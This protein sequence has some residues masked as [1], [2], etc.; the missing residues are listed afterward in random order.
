M[1]RPRV[2]TNEKY[3]ICTFY[4][5]FVYVSSVARWSRKSKF[6][7]NTL[8]VRGIH[9][10]GFVL[11]LCV[12]HSITSSWHRVRSIQT[13]A[14][15]HGGRREKRY[16]FPVQDDW[17]HSTR[18]F[19]SSAWVYGRQK[20]PTTSRNMINTATL[21]ALDIVEH[22]FYNRIKQK[23]VIVLLWQ[24]RTSYHTQECRIHSS[25]G[26]GDT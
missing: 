17:Q 19:I 18:S 21:S 23:E 8:V 3:R 6:W 7:S 25:E 1:S 24:A 11:V 2:E 10:N 15:A 16:L 5:A 9:V 14:V 20:Y 26:T 12:A 4:S 22:R 13:Q